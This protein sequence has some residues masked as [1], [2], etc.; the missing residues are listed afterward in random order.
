MKT[1]VNTA[2]FVQGTDSHL[3]GRSRLPV[4]PSLRITV[5]ELKTEELLVNTQM[6]WRREK[7]QNSAVK[8]RPGNMTVS[9]LSFSSLAQHKALTCWNACIPL[10]GG[11]ECCKYLC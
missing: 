7:A 11:R 3:T 9:E 5:A 1:H 10:G 6:G 4:P 8:Y 2:W